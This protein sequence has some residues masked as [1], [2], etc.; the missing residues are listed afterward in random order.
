MPKRSVDE[1]IVTR[2]IYLCWRSEQGGQTALDRGRE[3][4]DDDFRVRSHWMRL[5]LRGEVPYV[6]VA[7]GAG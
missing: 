3:G 4:R 2:S 7:C 1:V 5:A 6:G